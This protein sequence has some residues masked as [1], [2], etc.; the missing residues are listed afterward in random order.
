MSEFAGP[1]RGPLKAIRGLRIHRARAAGRSRAGKN[2]TVD[3]FQL[4]LAPGV[5]APLVS[6]GLHPDSFLGRHA[7]IRPGERVLVTAA[8]S[9]LLA[10]HARRAGAEVT[11][12]GDRDDA[13]AMERSFRLAEYEPPT[14]VA[15]A[16]DARFTAV[17]VAEGSS[18]DVAELAA[19]LERGGRLLMAAADRDG[20]DLR[21]ALTDAG[22]R[23][24]THVLRKDGVFGRMRVLSAWTPRGSDRA[25][26]VPGG[27][28]LAGARWVLRDR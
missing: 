12:L 25:G 21:T 10:L 6:G 18:P 26:Y 13:L 8:G 14:V 24:T 2:A 11:V 19:R 27:Q 7:E 4:M 16:G 3:G 28:S 22:L 5:D 1:L 9:G 20:A 23:W 15:D 17:L